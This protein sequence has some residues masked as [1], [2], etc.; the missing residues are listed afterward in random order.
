MVE[1]LGEVQPHGGDE[2]V[3]RLGS[4]RAF[5]KRPQTHDLGLEEV[6][7]LRKF[8][9]EARPDANKSGS[10][11][12]E[13]AQPSRMTV[14]IDHHAA[15]FLGLVCSLGSQPVFGSALKEE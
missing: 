11:V 1:H 9:K 6:S 3:F 5:F 7:R 4:Q 8:L 15:A 13:P 2:F 10:P 14:V 12:E